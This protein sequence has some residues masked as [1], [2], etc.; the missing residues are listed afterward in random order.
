MEAKDITAPAPDC[1]TLRLSSPVTESCVSNSPLGTGF[2]C[3]SKDAESGASRTST[4][5][6][7]TEGT[8]ST[9]SSMAFPN[10]TDFH[11]SES[12]QLFAFCANPRSIARNGTRFKSFAAS[13]SVSGWSVISSET[14]GKEDIHAEDIDGE[15]GGDFVA[16]P[17]AGGITNTPMV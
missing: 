3:W 2:Q 15:A 10:V 13:G 11:S 4:A 8:H 9:A 17:V 6:H 7:G 5:W 16:A 12:P 1:H 14:S